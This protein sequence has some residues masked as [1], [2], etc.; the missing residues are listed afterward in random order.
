ME[1]SASSKK[2]KQCKGWSRM[3]YLENSASKNS[4][5]EAHQI[6]NQQ[7]IQQIQMKTAKDDIKAKLKIDMK[8]N[9]KAVKHARIL[10]KKIK[11]QE[12]SIK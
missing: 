5:E 10:T 9:Q 12:K 3:H 4:K 2:V 7:W 8:I 6:K 11:R 1:I